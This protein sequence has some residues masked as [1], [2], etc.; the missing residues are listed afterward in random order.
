[1]LTI[2]DKIRA[3]VRHRGGT[4]DL[5]A[6]K[7]G[8]TRQNISLKLRRGNWKEEE[9]KQYADALGCDVE[10]VFTDR[11]TGEKL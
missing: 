10:I 2:E 8:C 7:L 6:E 11:A 3:I 4:L 9:L 5:L 1:M